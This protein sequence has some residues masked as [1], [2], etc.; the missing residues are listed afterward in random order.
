MWRDQP[1]R[2]AWVKSVSGGGLSEVTMPTDEGFL[3]YNQGIIE[4]TTDQTFQVVV[5]EGVPAPA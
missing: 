4:K 2:L 3:A 1:E 5:L